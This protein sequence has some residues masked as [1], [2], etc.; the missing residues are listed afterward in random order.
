MA[1]TYFIKSTDFQPDNDTNNS[2]T[3]IINHDQANYGLDK[4]YYKHGQ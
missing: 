4:R 3:C 1:N 2:L